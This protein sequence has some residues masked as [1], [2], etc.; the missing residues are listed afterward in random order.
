MVKLNDVMSNVSFIE[1]GV[2]QGNVLDPILF[3]LYINTLCDLNINGKLMADDTCLLFLEKSWEGVYLKATKDLNL[4]YKRLSELGLTMNSDKT[5]YMKFS[6]NKIPND[7]FPL[8]IHNCKN[9]LI[10]DIQ[11]C[12]LIN[13]ISKIRYLDIIIDNNMR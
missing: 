4:T 11:N 12:K 6:I 7:K 10:C 5:T 1:Y 13:Q 2:P 9:Q 8:I 3:I